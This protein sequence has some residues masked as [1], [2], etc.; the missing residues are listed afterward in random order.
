MLTPWVCG[1]RGAVDSV[2]AVN[3]D[4]LRCDGYLVVTVS[5]GGVAVLVDCVVT[6]TLMDG[7]EAVLG[8]DLTEKL[9]DLEFCNGKVVNHLSKFGLETKPPEE[10]VGGRVLGLSLSRNSEGAVEFCQGNKI[11]SLADLNSVDKKAIILVVWP[12]C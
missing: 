9:G 1:A 8:V 2:R 10:L 12:V 6:E 3:N 7:I 11:S 5:V 4:A